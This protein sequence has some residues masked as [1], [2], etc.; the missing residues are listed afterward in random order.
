MPSRRFKIFELL[1]DYVS[2]YLASIADLRVLCDDLE[3]HGGYQILVGK[4]E[5][6]DNDM[7]EVFIT[8]GPKKDDDG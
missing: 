1:P 6:D 5:A 2:L 8:F 3:R 4:R 7:I